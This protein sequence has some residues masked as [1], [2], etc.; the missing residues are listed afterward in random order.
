MTD[1]TYVMTDEENELPF[2]LTPEESRM[3]TIMRY[4]LNKRFKSFGENRDQPLSEYLSNEFGK[5]EHQ[6]YDINKDIADTGSTAKALVDVLDKEKELEPTKKLYK[7][8]YETTQQARKEEREK[9]F[10]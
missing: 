7:T 6:I 3:F 5:I 2:K 9:L 4:V 10:S 8:G 1:E